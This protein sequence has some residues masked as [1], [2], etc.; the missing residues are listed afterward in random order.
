MSPI[1][2]PSLAL[3]QSLLYILAGWSCGAIVIS[4]LSLVFFLENP[5]YGGFLWAW[6]SAVRLYKPDDTYIRRPIQDI[7]HPSVFIT[8]VDGQAIHPQTT[9]AYYQTLWDGCQAGIAPTLA[10]QSVIY[11]LRLADGQTTTTDPMPLFCFNAWD[12]FVNWGSVLPAAIF[13]WFSG[14]VILRNM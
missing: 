9:T 1:N 7:I 11:T 13:F 3:F 4:A 14:L 5:T 12:V 8:A 2:R 10:E 6:D